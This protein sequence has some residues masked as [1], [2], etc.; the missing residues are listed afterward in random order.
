MTNID[1]EIK[2]AEEFLSEE[3]INLIRTLVSGGLSSVL[4]ATELT[5]SENQATTSKPNGEED[6][7]SNLR[8]TLRSLGLVRERTVDDDDLDDEDLDELSDEFDEEDF[9]DD[10]EDA[11]TGDNEDAFDLE[12]IRRRRKQRRLRR[13]ERKRKLSQTNEPINSEPVQFV[14]EVEVIQSQIEIPKTPINDT[15]SNPPTPAKIRSARQS[16]NEKEINKSWFQIYFLNLIIMP[17][18]NYLERV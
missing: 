12:A 9:D 3:Q 1:A 14:Q 7:W 13:L 10:E 16:Q 5:V 4:S 15:I 8:P 2:E 6:K 17:K 18:K 11:E